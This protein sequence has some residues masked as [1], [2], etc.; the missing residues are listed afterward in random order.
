M[1]F[2]KPVLLLKLYF[3]RGG[4]FALAIDLCI[5]IVDRASYSLSFALSGSE[6]YRVEIESG[7]GTKKTNTNTRQPKSCLLANRRSPH[8]L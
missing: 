3:L 2:V 4:S 1:K 5:G 8:G 7:A 6:R